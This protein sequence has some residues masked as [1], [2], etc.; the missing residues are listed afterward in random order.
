M[1]RSGYMHPDQQNALA[2]ESILPSSSISSSSSTSSRGFPSGPLISPLASLGRLNDVLR[3]DA[4][5]PGRPDEFRPTL[6][7]DAR[8]EDELVEPVVIIGD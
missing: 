2:T 5:L 6:D 1:L 7:K 4:E 3:L 8:R